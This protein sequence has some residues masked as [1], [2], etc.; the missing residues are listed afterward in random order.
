MKHLC[1]ALGKLYRH[2]KEITLVFCLASLRSHRASKGS[3]RQRIR[4]SPSGQWT[5]F[6]HHTVEISEIPEDKKCNWNEQEMAK[7]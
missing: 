6:V 3:Y 4:N 5:N 1:P 2:A 7:I